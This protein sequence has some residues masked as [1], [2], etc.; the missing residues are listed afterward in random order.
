VT[1]CKIRRPIDKG[2]YIPGIL[3]EARAIT[4]VLNEV[5]ARLIQC[6]KK[7]VSVESWSFAMC[8]PSSIMRSKLGLRRVRSKAAAAAS[9]FES[10]RNVLIRLPALNDAAPP[11]IN[12]S[13]TRAGVDTMLWS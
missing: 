2:L 11:S 13:S 9:F 7:L 4:Y 12:S 8:D 3:I 6:R 1:D 10:Q 5:A